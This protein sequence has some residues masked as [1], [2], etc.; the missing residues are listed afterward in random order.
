MPDVHGSNGW[1]GLQS[2]HRGPRPALRTSMA[3]IRGQFLPW[4]V[5]IPGPQSLL[6]SRPRTSSI[7]PLCTR[8]CLSRFQFHLGLLSARVQVL[9]TKTKWNFLTHKKLMEGKTSHRP[10]SPW[11]PLDTS[12]NPTCLHG[13][14]SP[15]HP[16]P[17][18]ILPTWADA[19]AIPRSRGPL[20]TS[21]A[22]TQPKSPLSPFLDY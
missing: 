19:P 10:Y 22:L 7:C 9:W 13:S 16:Q 11:S 1:T 20:C 21:P 17:V 5:V 15:A 6:F 8:F 2:E 3:F 14:I 18:S 4:D 12:R